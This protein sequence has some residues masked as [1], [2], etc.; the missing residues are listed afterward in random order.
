MSCAYENDVL[1]HFYFHIFFTWSTTSTCMITKLDAA[2]ASFTAL[3]SKCWIGTSVF[4]KHS[5]ISIITIIPE[6][7]KKIV[8]LNICTQS[9]IKKLC[10]FK[11]CSWN[12]NWLKTTYDDFQNFSQ[13]L[14]QILKISNFLTLLNTFQNMQY[15]FL[16]TAL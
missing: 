15:N 1:V 11:P 3:T 14:D 4:T 2:V 8:Q 10:N 9:E 6:I 12:I 16:I 7:K 13:F 5:L